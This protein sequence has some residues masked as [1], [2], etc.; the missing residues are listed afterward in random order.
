MPRP[1][2]SAPRAGSANSVVEVMGA[3]PKVWNAFDWLEIR[4]ATA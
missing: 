2:G 1:T 3:L 4:V